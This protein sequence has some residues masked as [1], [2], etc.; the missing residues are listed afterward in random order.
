M[1]KR[2]YFT[3]HVKRSFMLLEKGLLY[4]VLSLLLG[5]R[6]QN[7]TMMDYADCFII[8]VLWLYNTWGIPTKH[9]VYFLMFISIF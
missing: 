1:Q 7:S 5:E 3:C 9:N 4:L 2:E 8:N 6:M